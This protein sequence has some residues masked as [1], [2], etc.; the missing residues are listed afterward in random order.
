[1]VSIYHDE[2]NEAGFSK[3]LYINTLV[4]NYSVYKGSQRAIHVG[5]VVFLHEYEGPLVF[6]IRI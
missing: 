3:G 2:T 5:T 4:H 6:K 1:M